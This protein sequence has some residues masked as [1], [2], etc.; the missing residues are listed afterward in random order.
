MSKHKTASSEFGGRRSADSGHPPFNEAHPPLMED[1]D[2]FP[3]DR[4][5][6]A[7]IGTPLIVGPN[8]F[9]GV[10]DPKYPWVGMP[11]SSPD[12]WKRWKELQAAQ[13][14]DVDHYLVVRNQYWARFDRR[15]YGAATTA[16]VTVEKGISYTHTE[17]EHESTTTR[18]GVQL[19]L[20]LGSDIFGAVPPV[21]PPAALMQRAIPL[22]QRFTFIAPMV[23]LADG[24]GDGDNPAGGS[25][26][27]AKFSYE[28]SHTLEFTKTDESS[29]HETITI[30]TETSFAANTQYLYWQICNEV[31]LF[32][33]SSQ[34]SDNDVL[35]KGDFISR[36]VS[37][38]DQLYVQPFAMGPD[39]DPADPD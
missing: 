38:T 33:V 21:P 3:P 35:A 10:H 32:R 15:M 28:F 29:F 39:T 17:V 14:Q 22:S 5:A 7:R 16:T 34:Q 24:D 20:N 11:H 18:L 8:N 31:L 37:R 2:I 23:A 30:S 6:C 36:V 19:G 27:D 12:Q 13:K 9:F 25:N 4:S 26:L 1:R